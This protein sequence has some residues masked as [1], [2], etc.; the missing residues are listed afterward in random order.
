M[1]QQAVVVYRIDHHD[2]SGILV[3]EWKHGLADHVAVAVD[4]KCLN[5]RDGKPSERAIQVHL[6]IA[7]D[8]M[9]H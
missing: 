1:K 2:E 6:G 3:S 4:A 7:D 5:P 8:F 9:W